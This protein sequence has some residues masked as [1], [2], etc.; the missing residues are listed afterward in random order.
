MTEQEKELIKVLDDC[1]AEHNITE[2]N[3]YIPTCKD[4]GV[5]EWFAQA[6]IQRYPQILAEKVW[7]GFN[8]DEGPRPYIPKNFHQKNIEV[9]IREV[10]E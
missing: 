7:E 10:K 5:L 1:L 4:S 3:A 9:F 8:P 2:N 6:L